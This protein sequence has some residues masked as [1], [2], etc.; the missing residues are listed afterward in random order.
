MILSV[1]RQCPDHIL[2]DEAQTVRSRRTK[3][4]EAVDDL[5]SIYR[6]CL[7]GTPIINTTV[8]AYGLLRFLRL[9]PWYEWQEFN[10]S[11]GR[12]EK[13]NRALISRGAYK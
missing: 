5:D 3:V 12:H 2:P 8:D 9:R 11:I 1:I 10:G 4:S 6:W 7:T 13:R